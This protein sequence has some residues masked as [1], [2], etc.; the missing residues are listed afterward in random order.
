MVVAAR[1]CGAM[2]RS[3][4]LYTPALSDAANPRT[5]PTIL[6]LLLRYIR[7]TLRRDVRARAFTRARL[8]IRLDVRALSSAACT[9][10]AAV[11]LNYA[12]RYAY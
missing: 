9:V 6:L 10:I 3:T 4:T 12:R 7:D 11:T 5:Y 2:T 1:L 8:V